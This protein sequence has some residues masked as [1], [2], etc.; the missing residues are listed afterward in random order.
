MDSSFDETDVINSGKV[1]V[2]RVERVVLPNGNARWISSTRAPIRDGRAAIT[3]LMVIARDITRRKRIEEESR[4]AGQRLK[5]V[6]DLAGEAIIALDDKLRIIVFNQQAEET[7]GY[8]AAEA[9]GQHLN[10]LLPPH[11]IEQH[12]RN[13]LEFRN[14]PEDRKQMDAPGRVKGR[15]KS[16]EEFPVEASPA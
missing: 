11:A 1:D 16:G 3:G 10:M 6:L 14:S 8:T 13:V 5:R 15:R 12:N 7:F 2:D 4:I 9:L